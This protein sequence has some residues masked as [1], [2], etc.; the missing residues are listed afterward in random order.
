MTKNHTRKRTTTYKCDNFNKKLAK[1]TDFKNHISKEHITC[2]LCKKIFPTITSL[3][4]HITAVND[5]LKQIIKSRK[6]TLLKIG[7]IYNWVRSQKSIF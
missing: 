7:D 1:Q 5:K 6:K 3:N 2:T 4:I